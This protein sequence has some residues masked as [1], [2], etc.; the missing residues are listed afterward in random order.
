MTFYNVVMLR[1]IVFGNGPRFSIW[2]NLTATL[3]L[4]VIQSNVYLFIFHRPHF[5]WIYEGIFMCGGPHLI[6]C[7]IAVN[8][9]SFK[10]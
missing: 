8:R 9:D 3:P 2:A 1:P 4:V 7:V 6:Y 5:E 10:S